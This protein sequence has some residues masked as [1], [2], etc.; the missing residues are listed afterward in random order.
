MP[1]VSIRIHWT[2]LHEK[3]WNKDFCNFNNYIV[4]SMKLLNDKDKEIKKGI[5]CTLSYSLLVEWKIYSF[6]AFLAVFDCLLYMC[7]S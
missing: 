4:E 5:L 2:I 6:V 1:I 3:N 7:S